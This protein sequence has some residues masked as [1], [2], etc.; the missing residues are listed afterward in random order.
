MFSSIII[1][2]VMVITLS[3]FTIEKLGKQ[4]EEI[5]HVRVPSISSTTNLFASAD[6][7]LQIG[8]KLGRSSTN[9]Q[10]RSYFIRLNILLDRMGKL[11]SLRDPEGKASLSKDYINKLIGYLRTSLAFLNT[12]AQ[13][14]LRVERDQKAISNNLII[15][16]NSYRDINSV[17]LSGYY[18]VILS[19][20]N[21]V[22]FRNEILQ[23]ERL[24]HNFEISAIQL[25]SSVSTVETPFQLTKINKNRDQLEL[26][27][28]KVE[29]EY[30]PI[31]GTRSPLTELPQSLHKLH[32]EWL[33]TQANQSTAIDQ[34]QNKIIQLRLILNLNIKRT[35]EAVAQTSADAKS[36]IK[37]RTVQLGLFVSLVI[38]LSF[39]ASIV[40]IRKS[41][42]HRLT[43]LG[44][45]MNQIARGELDTNIERGGSDEIT[46]MAN[47]LEVFRQTAIEVEDQQIKTLIEG[48]V[49]GLIMA[50]KN[51][52]V[53][54]MNHTARILFGYEE[55][56][57]KNL[58]VKQLVNTDEDKQLMSMFRRCHK[59][60]LNNDRSMKFTKVQEFE[61]QRLNGPSF[62]SDIAVRSVR[63][64]N[65][66]R[67]ILT[68][69]DV[70][71]RKSSQ[72]MLEETVTRR[73]AELQHTNNNLI[74][75]NKT[76]IKTEQALRNT[77]DELV[78]ASKLAALG[79][80]ASGISHEFNQPLMAISS[81]IHNATTLL[82]QKQYSDTNDALLKIEAQI[83]RMMELASH[84]QTM[85]RQPKI[86]FKKTNI[87]SVL[88][89]SLSLFQVRIR[90]EGIKVKQSPDFAS[91][92]ATTDALRLEQVFIN[93]ISNGLDA[94][95]DQDKKTLSIEF[96]NDNID[97]ISIM[98]K[99]TGPGIPKNIMDSLF[100]P[101]FTTKEVGEGM[102]LG[103][104]ISY[105]IVR[106]LGGSLT[107]SNESKGGACFTIMLPT[108]TSQSRKTLQAEEIW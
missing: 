13:Y 97:Y 63:K 89:R 92:Y 83:S 103:L 107:V 64:R 21:S 98:V 80:M 30:G 86:I 69:Y 101:F 91:F 1:I 17:I 61:A 9:E 20:Y 66:E 62:A 3:W 14:R 45:S 44:Q 68:I 73:T 16:L 85:A 70:S 47:A 25:S 10:R 87:G 12:N 71:E 23:M 90:Q 104:S 40:F 49:A 7:F 82:K 79:K 4:I 56:E 59:G 51:G 75:E 43:A 54:Y 60:L 36:L 95:C 100:D 78:Q 27:F 55:S 11:S 15:L 102:G 81:W 33:E 41:L 19:G 8:Q 84:L 57:F 2:V 29:L 28:D 76:R 48:S 72:Q 93:L 67:Y 105:N 31:F 106:S 77:K 108:S 42:I 74:I 88:D 53:E 39:L 35:Q 38:V 18:S 37:L 6:D 94:L 46:E 26:I 22:K 96:T 52:H 32:N 99:D 5:N 50:N 58:N 34:I 24:I 65:G